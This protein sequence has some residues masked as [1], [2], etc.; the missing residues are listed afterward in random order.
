MTL[1]REVSLFRNKTSSILARN[2]PSRRV[3]VSEVLPP[4][5]RGERGRTQRRNDQ[6]LSFSTLEIR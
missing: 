5:R 1:A 3:L 4:G 6:L 2:E